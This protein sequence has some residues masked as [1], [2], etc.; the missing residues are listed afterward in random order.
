MKY[1]IFDKKISLKAISGNCDLIES[2]ETKVGH[3]ISEELYLENKKLFPGTHI[4]RKINKSEWID[5]QD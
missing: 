5:V 3:V 2:I 4:I 1:L